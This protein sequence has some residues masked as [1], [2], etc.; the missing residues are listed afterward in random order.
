MHPLQ[1]AAVFFFARTLGRVPVGVFWRMSAAALLMVFARY[2]G[3]AGFFNPTLGVAV[4]RVLALYPGRDV[5]RRHARTGAQVRRVVRLGYF[6]IRLIPTIGWAIYP[7]L[8]FVDVVIGAGQGAGRGRALYPLRSHQPHHPVAHRS[9][10]AGQ[11]R[12]WSRPRF[13]GPTVRRKDIDMTGADAIAI[14][15]LA[16]IV[17]AVVVYLPH[18]L[19]RHSSKDQSLSAPGRAAKRWSWAGA[20]W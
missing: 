19:Y 10:V 4:D 3:D 6:V 1:V 14:L 20:R 2:L 17:I 13:P 15:I 16:T 18:W 12:Y 7:I 5:F 11:E 9:A 8:H